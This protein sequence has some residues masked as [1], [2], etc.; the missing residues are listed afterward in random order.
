MKSIRKIVAI[1]LIAIGSAGSTQG[2]ELVWHLV[3]DDGAKYPVNQIDYIIQQDADSGYDI[4]LADGSVRSGVTR[5]SFEY[6]EDSGIGQV[7][8]D[9]EIVAGPYGDVITVTGLK[10]G[11]EICLYNTQG[12]LLQSVRAAGSTP[13]TINLAS[14]PAGV[15]LLKTTNT[16]LKFLKR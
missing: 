15:Y 7:S 1:L 9:R 2:G 10:A 4:V 6:C 13:V 11:M 14:L 8:A 16:T 3:T 12:I 5:S